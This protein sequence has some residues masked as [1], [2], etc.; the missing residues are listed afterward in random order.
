MI[1]ARNQSFSG[2]IFARYQS[3]SRKIF[4]RYL[5]NMVRKKQH[6]L[7]A[8]WFHKLFVGHTQASYNSPTRPQVKLGVTNNV[9]ARPA[10]AGRGNPQCYFLVALDSIQGLVVYCQAA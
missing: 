7:A 4:A 8:C 9:I 2:K 1:F 6:T 10:P 5:V 3:F